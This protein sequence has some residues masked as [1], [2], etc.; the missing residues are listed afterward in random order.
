MEKFQEISGKY[1][2]YEDVRVN[3]DPL[4]ETDGDTFQ[5]LIADAV[6][7]KQEADLYNIIKEH[8][9]MKNF[10]AKHGLWETFLNDD[11]FLKYLREDYVGE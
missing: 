7:K 9:I 6:R 11:E 4:K 3:L 1:N 5:D 8:T 2:K 10:I